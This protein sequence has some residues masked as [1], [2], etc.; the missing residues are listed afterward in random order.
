MDRICVCNGRKIRRKIEEKKA[1]LRI[2]SPM[3]KGGGFVMLPMQNFVR[4]HKNLFPLG[5]NWVETAVRPKLLPIGK[6][7]TKWRLK[8][9]PYRG[10][11]VE[12]AYVAVEKNG[13]N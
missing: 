11:W 7:Q 8:I 9:S 3:S 5:E 10:K 2:I 12:F 6:K 1:E 13:K 4:V